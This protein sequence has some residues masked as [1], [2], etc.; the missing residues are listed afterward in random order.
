MDLEMSNPKVQQN[1]SLPNNT[2][3]NETEKENVIKSTFV[4]TFEPSTMHALPNIIRNR[5]II[6]KVF[7]S[8][9]F[10]AAVGACIYCK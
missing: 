8:I 10:L 4:E 1:S 6:M 2:E 3:P 7:W 9:L 5:F